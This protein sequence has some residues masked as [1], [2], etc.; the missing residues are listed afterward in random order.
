MEEN[1][2][3]AECAKRELVEE[4]GLKIELLEYIGVVREFQKTYNFIH[5]GFVARDVTDQI[6]NLEPDKCEGWEWVDMNNL[7]ENIL[8]GHKAMMHLYSIGGAMAEII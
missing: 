7:P 4:V 2:R 1:E 5:F 3:L 8:A 6:S